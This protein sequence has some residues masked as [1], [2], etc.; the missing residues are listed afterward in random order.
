MLDKTVGFFDFYDLDKFLVPLDP[1]PPLI[2]FSS[3]IPT[4]VSEFFDELYVLSIDVSGLAIL[5]KPW[6]YCW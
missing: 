3:A 5:L 2:L 6:I 4:D 1:P